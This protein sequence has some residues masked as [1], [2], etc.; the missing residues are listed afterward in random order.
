MVSVAIATYNGEKYIQKQ[1][2]SILNQT[3]K[4]DEV[5][6]CDDRSTD[7]TVDI[8]RRFIKDNVLSNWQVFVNDKNVGFCLNFYGAVSKC[9]GDV[10]FLSDQDDEWCKQ[11]IERMTLCLNNHPEIKVLSSRYDVIDANSNV[12]ENSGV[13]YIG[14]TL[15]GSIDYITERSL[16]GCSY[17]RG[18]SLC[19]KRE[20]SELI[21]PIDL[22]SLLAH[23]WL[24][25]YLGCITGKT[26]ILNEKLAHYRY[27]G[28][29]ASIYA[30]DKSKNTHDIKKRILGLEES[31]NGHSY[32]LTLTKDETNKNILQSFIKFEKL[33]IKYL[34]NKNIFLWLILVLF[35][36][37]Y[38]KYYKGNGI[39]VWLGDLV[40]VLKNKG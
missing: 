31:V 25:S 16:I 10:I 17:I 20:V 27:H 30:I 15:D 5:I 40:Y 14:N 22:K 4:A 28:D 18:F 7:S 21:K 32:V 12:I 13:K 38:N 24:I 39:R 23:D 36:K 2:D 26:A 35:M 9:K 19:L 34:R 37:N 6:I 33:R 29:N 11:K 3:V 8:C 1:L